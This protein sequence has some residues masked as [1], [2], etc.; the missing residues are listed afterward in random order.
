MEK[1]FKHFVTEDKKKKVKIITYK[2][3]DIFINSKKP[4]KVI[5]KVKKEKE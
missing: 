4:N 2:N 5:A 3:K 1:D